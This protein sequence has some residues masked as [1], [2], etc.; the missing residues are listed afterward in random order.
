MSAPQIPMEP[1]SSPAHPPQGKHYKK[2]KHQWEEE[3]NLLIDNE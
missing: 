3:Q 1:M 2:Y